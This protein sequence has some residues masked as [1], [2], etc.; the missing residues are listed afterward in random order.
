MSPE[1]AGLKMVELNVLEGVR[2]LK[3]KNVVLEAI[4]ER[5]LQVHGVIYD[6]G[7]GVVREVGTN[8]PEAVIKARLTAFKTDA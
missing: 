2:T 8:E 3:Q 4:Q 1:D 5:G 7:S 6:V